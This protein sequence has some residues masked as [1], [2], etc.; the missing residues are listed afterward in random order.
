MAGTSLDWLRSQTVGIDVEVQLLDGTRRAHVNLDNASST[1]T[2]KPVLDRVNEF[3]RFYS[4]VGR[5]TGFK[6]QIATHSY[7]E[8][9]CI[10]ARFLN[11]D[12]A[13]DTVIFTRNTTESLNRLAAL[14]PFKPDSIVITT[15]MEHHSND[16][17]WR[18]RARV[19]HTGI[20][21]DGSLDLNDL[22]SKLR[23]NRGKVALV[24]V[25]GAS[26]V[27]GWVNPVHTIAR[28]AHAHGARLVVDA[29]QTA[30]H[31]P[32]DMRPAA[33]PEHIDFLAFSGH[34]TYAPFG[35]GVLAGDR[36]LLHAAEPCLV[37]GGVV[38]L[39]TCDTAI[40]R[41]LPDRE[42]AGTPNIVGTVGLAAAI[43]VLESIGWDAIQQ[44]EDTL[45]RYALARLNQIPR[46]RVYGK[47]SADDLSD[48][49]GVIAFG[50]D[51][52]SC[53]LGAAVLAYEAGI[54]ARCGLFCAHPYVLS[55]L[56]VVGDE[57]NRLTARARA[58]EPLGVAGLIRASIGAYNSLS[59]IDALCD[60]LEA[61]V[62][63]RHA[64]YEPYMNAGDLRPAG[65]QPAS[66]E[67]CFRLNPD[68][69]VH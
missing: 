6:S 55:L 8:A 11:L 65:I 41:G 14:Y 17:P 52:K 66:L 44:H 23:Q 40:W 30:P 15:M 49:L 48:R 9:R 68:L 39:V 18:R 4:N 29:A 35:I 24:T 28:M 25:A 22:E 36:N 69:K 3:L 12:T 43:K 34:K 45:T 60:C 61:L 13:N 56:G 58:G 2:F 50:L 1:P 7:E 57:L 27:T 59:D 19:I 10:V 54:G 21:P 53:Q 42:E 63:D 62:Q 26:N 32:I 64:R 38:D 33:D 16:L 51:G 67:E 46:I 20:N 31:R 5:G 37:G 47:T